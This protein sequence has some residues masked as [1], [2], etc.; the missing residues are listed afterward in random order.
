MPTADL[1]IVVKHLPEP[2]WIKAAS[3]RLPLIYAPVDYYASAADI[4]A[5]G[6]LLRHFARIIV[7]CERL[8]RYFE[9]YAP[10]VYLDHHVKFAASRPADRRTQG[11]FLWI[12]V[13][14]NL[15]PLIE[16][17]NHHPVPG[18]LVVL[19]NFEDPAAVPSATA[20]GFRPGQAM[21][22][23]QWTAERHLEF[24]ARARAALDVKGQDFRSRH[25]PPAKAIDFLAAGVPLAMNPDSSPVEHLAAMGFAVPSP[26]DTERWLS[27]DYWEETQ[28]FGQALRE[29]LSLRRIALRLK[30]V[31]DDVLAGHRPGR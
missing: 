19:S 7:H 29:V 5:D 22:I 10:V 30:R 1:G 27:A 15:A 26:L 3:R 11:S 21:R 18:E 12:G 8:R 23:V 16:W 14:T 13:R 2:A 4:D 9:P 24:T 25:K 6:P 31:I 17:I 28:R 20:L